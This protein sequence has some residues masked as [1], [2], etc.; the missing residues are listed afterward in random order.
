MYGVIC[1]SEERTDRNCPAALRN[2]KKER[3]IKEFAGIISVFLVSPNAA[4]S[5]LWILSLPPNLFN[6]KNSTE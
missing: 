6:N 3:E 2:G 1:S 5:S 4:A